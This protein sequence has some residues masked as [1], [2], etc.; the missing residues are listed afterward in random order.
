MALLLKII[1]WNANGLPQHINELITF[2]CDNK[3][4]NFGDLYYPKTSP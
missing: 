3:I 1:A 2:I 4:V